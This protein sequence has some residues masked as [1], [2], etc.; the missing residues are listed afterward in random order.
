ME[1]IGNAI[2]RFIYV[3]PRCIGAKDKRVAWILIEK[4][5]KGGFPESID[6]TWELS[7]IQQRLDY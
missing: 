2:G 6:L 4:E 5:F 3:D 1:K 7:K